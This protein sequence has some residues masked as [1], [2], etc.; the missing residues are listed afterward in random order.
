M[1]VSSDKFRANFFKLLDKLENDHIEIVITKQGKPLARLSQINAD[2]PK[3]PLLGSLIGVG[4]TVDKPL[5]PC[6]ARLT[7]FSL[8]PG[9]WAPTSELWCSSRIPGSRFRRLWYLQYRR[10]F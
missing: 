6:S 3:D 1:Q 10:S 8:Q 2:A 5:R 4:H 7:P 9:P